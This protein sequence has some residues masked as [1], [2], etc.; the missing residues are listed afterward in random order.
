MR[1]LGG[2]QDQPWPPSLI[3]R[4]ACAK[5]AKKDNKTGPPSRTIVRTSF[6][7]SPVLCRWRRDHRRAGSMVF[8]VSR[9]GIATQFLRHALVLPSVVYFFV[10]LTRLLVVSILG[11][12]VWRQKT[13][14]D[15]NEM[16]EYSQLAESPRS[17]GPPR[18]QPCAPGLVFYFLLLPWRGGSKLYHRFEAGF[19]KRPLAETE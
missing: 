3:F 15:V 13:P 19:V 6:D 8:A 2:A 1:P 17:A 7:T 4:S 14:R 5:R 18:P 9:F 12:F 11:G 10:F 16:A